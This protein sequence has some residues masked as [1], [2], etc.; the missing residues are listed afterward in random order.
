MM[1]YSCFIHSNVL[2]KVKALLQMMPRFRPSGKPGAIAPGIRRGARRNG[3]TL[4][5]LLVRSSS[6][7]QNFRAVSLVPIFVFAVATVP[8]V[9]SRAERLDVPQHRKNDAHIGAIDTRTCVKRTRAV[10]LGFRF[11][12]KRRLVC[13]L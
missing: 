1:S 4:R 6:A 5:W 12:T 8:A 10:M 11:H 7:T 3:E 13:R 2:I 9:R